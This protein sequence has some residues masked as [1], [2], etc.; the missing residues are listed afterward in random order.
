VQDT[1]EMQNISSAI[2]DIAALLVSE[3]E[4][5][6]VRMKLSPQ[7]AVGVSPVRYEHRLHIIS[8]AISATGIGGVSCE[9]RILSTYKSKAITATGCGGVSCEVRTASAYK[10]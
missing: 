5:E 9:V 2:E 7:Q 4:L 1:E 3:H 10:K 8:K 6:K